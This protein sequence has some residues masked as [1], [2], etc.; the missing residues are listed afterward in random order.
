MLMRFMIGGVQFREISF[1]FERSLFK[2]IACEERKIELNWRPMQ[3][4]G[5]SERGRL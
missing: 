2:I 4:G 5:G 1:N 3:N